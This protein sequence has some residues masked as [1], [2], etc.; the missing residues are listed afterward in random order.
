M[1]RIMKVALVAAATTAIAIGSSTAAQ[2]S[3]SIDATGKGFVGKGDVQTALG[4]NNSTLQKAVDAKSLVFTAQQPTWQAL[5]RGPIR[6]PARTLE[7]RPEPS[8]APRPASSPPRR[9]FLTT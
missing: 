5:A 8:S 1:R 4:Y 2:A 7:R 6:S 9:W 3:V